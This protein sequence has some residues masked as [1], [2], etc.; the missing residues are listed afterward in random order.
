MPPNQS[1]GKVVLPGFRLQRRAQL[2]LPERCSRRERSEL[3]ALRALVEEKC[4]RV[5]SR[6]VFPY[7]EAAPE[8]SAIK[9]EL[10]SGL[11]V[12]K[13]PSFQRS[14]VT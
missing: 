8:W 3:P 9:N 10:L 1:W 5:K 13:P 7:M 14:L 4:L 6:T 2:S 12:K 11:G